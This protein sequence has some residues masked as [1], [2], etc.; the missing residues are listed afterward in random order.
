MGTAFLHG[1]SGRT[2][3]NFSVRAYASVESLPETARENTIAVITEL[4]IGQV[5]T[6]CAAAPADC[7]DGDVYIALLSSSK[8]IF[9]ALKGMTLYC[10][11]GICFQQVDGV[12][13]SM[14][15]YIYQGDWIQFSYVWLGTLFDNGDQYED[16]TG[17]WSKDGYA[18][19][20]NYPN[21]G[22]VTVGE[23]IQCST[24]AA[25][26]SAQCG[27]VDPIDLTDFSAIHVTCSD[28]NTEVTTPPQL[29]IT[30]SK[31]QQN[32][33]TKS[34]YIRDAGTFTIDVSDLQGE[35]YISILTA[36]GTT[37]PYTSVTVTK[38]WLER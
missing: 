24:S 31:D 21:D 10:F 20:S 16:Y 35:H 22:V 29:W 13:T 11:P 17:G 19:S 12:W 28:V 5:F 26:T 27:T 36:G 2:G 6:N 9:N 37:T 4:P 23:T 1:N 14:D 15:A 33:A 25:Y 18:Y 38:V 8:V 3:L 30:T 7:S 34:E 32:E